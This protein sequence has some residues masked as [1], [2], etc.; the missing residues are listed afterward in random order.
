[1]ANS[2]LASLQRAAPAL[3]VQYALYHRDRR[4]IVTHFIGI[5]MIVFGVGVLLAR[6]DVAGI[7][8][9]W[10]TWALASL[11]YLTRGKL[12]LGLATSAVNALLFVGAHPLAL[13]ST[14]SFNPEGAVL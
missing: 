7:S 5:P 9:A 6:A 8:L 10:I 12:A 13:G 3:L 1:M 2:P 4:N 14:A 11:W